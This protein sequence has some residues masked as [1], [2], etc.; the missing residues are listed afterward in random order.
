MLRAVGALVSGVGKGSEG[1]EGTHVWYARDLHSLDHTQLVEVSI[2]DVPVLDVVRVDVGWWWCEGV[3][4]CFHVGEV[5][6]RRNE[7][8]RW[9]T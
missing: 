6:D 5:V 8:R 1:R 7:G 2:R 9:N 4:E 3:Y